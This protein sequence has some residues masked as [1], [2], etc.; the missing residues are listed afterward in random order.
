[1]SIIIQI[2][3][4]K[5]DVTTLSTARILELY[6]QLAFELDKPQVKRFATRPKAEGRLIGIADEARQ[7][8]KAKSKN[9]ETLVNDS[10]TKL[11][12]DGPNSFKLELSE[13]DQKLVE[14]AKKEPAP[15]S[16]PAPTPAPTAAPA[17][18]TA[19]WAKPKKEPASKIAYRPRPGSSQAMMYGL[20]A[21]PEGIDI[22]DFCDIMKGE[23]IKDK[24]LHTP[25][26]VWSCLRYLFVTSKGYGLSFDGSR[27]RL[28]VP[29]DERDAA[30]S[31]KKA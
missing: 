24:T 2:D 12:S 18:G 17:A 23:G 20:L 4:Q 11:V 19:R 30:G 3:D 5:L 14:K 13:S 28:L 31:G 29:A 16:T 8:G 27:I 6:N 9:N 21:R 25:P 1:M 7:K 15:A 26:S 22:Q 10:G